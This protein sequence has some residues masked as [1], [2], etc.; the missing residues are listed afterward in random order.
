M[1]R[2]FN[3]VPSQTFWFDKIKMKK[4]L[5]FIFVF[6][7]SYAKSGMDDIPS[8][9]QLCVQ[10]FN[11]YGMF[12]SGNL[13]ERHTHLLKFL[14]QYNCDIILLQE[15]WKDDHYQNLIQLSRHIGMQSVYFKKPYDN[16]KSGLAG[17]FKGRVQNSDIVYF[18]SVVESGLDFLY[19]FFKFIDKGFGVVQVSVPQLYR[20]SFLVFNFHLNHISQ[21][22][23]ISQ[24]LLYLKWMLENP[25]QDQ[26]VIAGGDFNFEPTSLEF[27]VVKKLLRFKDPYEQIRKKF[28]CTHLCEDSGYDWLHLFFG[29]S[30]KDYIFFRS[31]SKISFEPVDISI[32]PK[33][34]N[35]VTLSDH[36]GLRSIFQLN[37]SLKMNSKH[38]VSKELLEKR[39]K[40]FEETLYEVESFFRTV[41]RTDEINFIRSLHR[42]LRNPQSSVVHYLKY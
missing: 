2:R 17:L 12:Y 42:S 40:D 5:F 24:L 27:L 13:E 18:P 33:H 6:F 21:A 37:N 30:I 4:I 19:E 20:N 29:E 38:L 36:F 3:S 26:A 8:T 11:T 41:N 39:M 22:N 32:F 23:R 28:E 16:K 14:R 31:S 34:Y 15:V 10:T 7:I 35:D 25:Y 9:Q 1:C